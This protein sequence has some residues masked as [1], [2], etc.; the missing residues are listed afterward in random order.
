MSKT[1]TI[2]LNKGL[3]IDAV[4][5]ETFIGGQTEKAVDGSNNAKVYNETAGDEVV[6]ERKL[7]RT[8]RG[9]VGALEAFMV[10]FVDP[11]GTIKTQTT[12][13]DPEDDTKTITTETDTGLSVMDNLGTADAFNIYF[14][15]SDRFNKGLSSAIAQLMQ[16]YIINKMICLWWSAVVDRK[17][18]VQTY[19]ALANESLSSIRKCLQKTAPTPSSASYDDVSGTVSGGGIN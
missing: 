7:Q 12:T 9:A 5:T 13:K 6:H 4:K 3:I 2:S 18:D 11:S 8:L 10:D 1:L 16:E 17:N 19:M 15:V 14:A